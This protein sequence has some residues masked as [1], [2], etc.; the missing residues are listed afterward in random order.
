MKIWSDLSVLLKLSTIC[1]IVG[2]ILGLCAA[3]RA[4]PLDA[5]SPVDL[6]SS[7][8]QRTGTIPGYP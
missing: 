2:F 1:V 7:A 5:P 3:G 8:A 4:C 6:S